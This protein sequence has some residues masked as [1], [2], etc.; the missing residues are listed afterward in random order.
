MFF[1]TIFLC[2][3]TKIKLCCIIFIEFNRTAFFNWWGK[4]TY[5]GRRGGK[6]MNRKFLDEVLS[7]VE[8]ES[9]KKSAI[10][11]I[12]S[13]NGEDIEKHKVE[14]AT[15]KNE[16]KTKDGVIDNLNNKIKENE[17]I[18]IEAIKKEQFDLGKEE[19]TK[20]VE[21]FKKSVA[22]ENA[23]KSTKA[24]DI[25]LLSALIDNEKINYEE[26]D[27]KFEITGLDDQITEIKKSHDYLFEVEKSQEPTQR[28][29][30]GDGHTTTPTN[31]PSTLAGA[32]HD[33]YGK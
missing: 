18:D 25:K 33:K 11:S 22:L 24:K 17:N 9:I 12:M 6:K 20:E 26:K 4:S 21:T 16:I 5:K 28:V 31:Q 23:L 27:G 19:G 29:N 30:V 8:D 1:L 14:V 10:D 2:F 32:L 3:L 15:L 7:F 13:K